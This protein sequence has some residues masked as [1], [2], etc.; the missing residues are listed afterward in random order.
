SRYFENDPVCAS[1]AVAGNQFRCRDNQF[2]ADAAAPVDDWR[3]RRQITGLVPVD[4]SRCSLFVNPWEGPSV[5]VL[6]A[7]QVVFC[8]SSAGDLGCERQALLGIS[9]GAANY[10]A[11]G[12]VTPSDPGGAKVTN[13]E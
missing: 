6:G 10:C 2:D 7:E 9:N 12:G 13:D 11:A 3:K 1:R 8:V 5:L 4:G